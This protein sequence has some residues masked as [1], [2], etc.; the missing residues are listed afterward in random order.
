MTASRHTT[1]ESLCSRCKSLD[2]DDILSGR[3][4]DVQCREPVALFGKRSTILHDKDC[5]LCQALLS[6][7]AGDHDTGPLRRDE[8]FCMFAIPSQLAYRG[9]KQTIPFDVDLV[10][11][12]LERAKDQKDSTWLVV[13]IQRGPMDGPF[14][15]NNLPRSA[16]YFGCL[17]NL[18]DTLNGVRQRVRLINP[19]KADF[20]AI[21]RWLT[22]CME[23]HGTLCNPDSES[24]SLPVSIAVINCTTRDLEPLPAGAKFAALSYVWGER[25]STTESYPSMTSLPQTIEDAITVTA[26]VGIPFLWVDR[27]CVP[28]QDC[29]QKREQIQMMHKIYRQADLTIIAAAGDSSCYGLPGISTPRARAPSVDLCVGNHHL[30][31]TGRSVKEAIRGTAWASRAW[32]YQEGL[33][34][35][36]KL[37][38][39]DEQVYLHCMEREFRET[40]EQ[41]LDLLAQADVS[42]LSDPFR[43]SILHFIPE[44]A[45][46]EGVYSLTGDFSERRITYPSDRL[47]AFLGILNLFQ[48]AFPESFRHIWGQP[49]PYSTD[50]SVA[51]V[52][53]SALK[54]HIVGLAQRRPDFPSWSWVGWKGQAYPSA[55]SVYKEDITASLLL[56][57]GTVI[58]D[59]EM[60]RNLDT[61]QS[62]SAS[63]SK[64]ILIQAQTVHV[65]IRRKEGVYWNLRNMWK[66]SLVRGGTER[67]GITYHDG[68]L[69]TPEYEAG[70]SIYKDLEAGHTWLGIV[71]LNSDM[72]LVLKDMGDYYERFGYIDVD[73]SVPDVELGDYL[74]GHRLI[75]L[76]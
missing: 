55:N 58:D 27:Y 4:T 64:Y 74:L 10:D 75:R 14:W 76:G 72:V 44:N 31:S 37:I 45:G 20:E 24:R 70:D 53:V 42:D 34:S 17:A 3:W 66:L 51:D 13:R 39:T 23:Q 46:T 2:L 69:I 50:M 6:I 15:Y 33:V 26:E 71:F 16:H 48:D 35:R 68:F 57:D 29:P 60:L 43:C 30:V 7:A 59:A 1:D 49:I 67:H 19:A 47:N 5:P 21:K 8:N 65:K 12:V 25:T 28:Q 56:K 22:H 32:T 36:R 62:L 40:I 41:D 38:F 54:W 63:L 61:F 11:R 52:V 73:F 9:A 18:S